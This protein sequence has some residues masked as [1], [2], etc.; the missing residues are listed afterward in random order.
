ML[1]SIESPPVL[2]RKSLPDSLKYA[3]L[4]P[5]ETLTVIIASCLTTEQEDKVLAVL[6]DHKEAIGWSVAYLKGISPSICMHQIFCE[7]GAKPFRDTQRRLNPNMR[8]VV[9]NEIVKWLDAALFT[10]PLTANELVPLR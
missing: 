8:E 2:D 1:N 7:D 4:G 3:Y 6:K 9:K 5:N 10:L